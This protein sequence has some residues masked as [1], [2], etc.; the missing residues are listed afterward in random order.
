MTL[1]DWNDLIGLAREVSR[2][3]F[4]ELSGFVE[5]E[6]DANYLADVERQL[7]VRFP[8]SFKRIVHRYSFDEVEIS[9]VW[10]H[11]RHQTFA[12]TLLSMNQPPIKW[13]PDELRPDNLVLVASCDPYCFLLNVDSGAISAHDAMYYRD[14]MKHVVAKDFGLFV[15]GLGTLEYHHGTIGNQPNFAN[16]LHHECGADDN[17]DFWHE[18]SDMWTEGP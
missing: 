8:N 1:I 2:E 18:W 15:L 13:W 17:N 10:F 6:R 5:R 7:A 4:S 3:S 11:F 12:Q 14:P 9:E 16:A